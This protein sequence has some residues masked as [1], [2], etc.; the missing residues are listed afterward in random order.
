MTPGEPMLST[1]SG[2]DSRASKPFQAIA[3][4]ITALIVAPT[5]ESA[6]RGG[7]VENF[8]VVLSLLAAVDATYR[9]ARTATQ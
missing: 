1:D 5:A 8:I 3:P 2:I 9:R 4:L 6:S 7:V